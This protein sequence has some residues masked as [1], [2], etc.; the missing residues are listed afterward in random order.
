MTNR[1]VP[2]MGFFIRQASRQRRRCEECLAGQSTASAL[3]IE[4]PGCV[5]GRRGLFPQGRCPPALCPAA[6][7]GNAPSGGADRRPRRPGL[8]GEGRPVTW[9]ARFLITTELRTW[10]LNRI[11]PVP[12]AL[13]RFPTLTSWAKGRPNFVSFVTRGTRTKVSNPD[14]C[15]CPSYNRW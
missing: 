2:G 5:V 14:R 15:I 4:F 9:E 7:E 1:D 10:N 12:C 13:A 8:K 3:A 11:T 6:L